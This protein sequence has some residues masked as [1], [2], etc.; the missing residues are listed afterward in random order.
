M[1]SRR[2]TFVRCPDSLSRSGSRI[3]NSTEGVVQERYPAFDRRGHAHLV[4]L[5]QQFLQVGLDV[6][7]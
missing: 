2:I 1:T 6:D 7:V 5:H 3:V 4:L